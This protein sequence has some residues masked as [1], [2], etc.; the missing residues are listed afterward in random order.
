MLMMIGQEVALL[1]FRCWCCL[2]SRLTSFIISHLQKESSSDRMHIVTLNSTLAQ[3]VARNELGCPCIV[4]RTSLEFFYLTRFNLRPA[5]NVS[6]FHFC[7]MAF[8]GCRLRRSKNAWNQRNRRPFALPARPVRPMRWH[9]I[10]RYLWQVVVTWVN[11]STSKP[12]A[13]HPWQ[14]P[15]YLV[16]E[17]Q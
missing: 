6:I 10:R 13:A 15:T 2:A 4:P 7:H 11:W 8:H 16:A 1:S 14:L 3:L 5:G 17:P 9:K 12:R